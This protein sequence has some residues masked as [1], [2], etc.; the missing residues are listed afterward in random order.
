MNNLFTNPIRYGL[1]FGLVGGT[2]YAITGTAFNY[3]SRGEFTWISILG[4]FI[5]FMVSMALSLYAYKKAS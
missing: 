5:W 1:V 2:V 3:F 4:G